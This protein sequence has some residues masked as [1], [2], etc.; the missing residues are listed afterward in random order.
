M[1]SLVRKR[2]H[3]AWGQTALLA[4]GLTGTLGLLLGADASQTP[5]PAATDS[6]AAAKAKNPYA[7]DHFHT[8]EPGEYVN[9][10]Q[11]QRLIGLGLE[12]YTTHCAGCHGDQGDGDGPAAARL[13]VKPRNF[14]AGV[15]KFRST[16]Q[17]QLPLEADLHRTITKGLPGASMPAF[18][19]M[20]ENDRVAV[21]EYL[22]TFVPDWDKLARQREVVPVPLAP[23]DFGSE[24]RIGRGRVV[25]LTMQCGRCHGMEG[26]GTNATIGYVDDPALGHIRPRNFTRGRYRGGNN[27]E[28][29]YRTFNTGLGGAMPKFD[30]SVI[31]YANQ[32]TLATQTAYMFPGEMKKL[33]PYAKQFAAD[34][35]A[36]FKLTE[37]EKQQLV[38]RNNW[39]LVSY[40]LSLTKDPKPTAPPPAPEVAPAAEA[41]T[42]KAEGNQTDSTSGDADGY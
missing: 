13:L 19:L 32:Q 29:V 14:K 23:M 36:L 15:F 9:Y 34:P 22:K 35:G 28:D 16:K 42:G 21:I 38:E 1:T 24:E 27:P 3:R 4:V 30:A 5:P 10:N 33:E 17:L 12:I 41:G 18:P 6:T 40:V 25:Y 8:N 39:D 11:R 2:K 37:T 26:A 31:L 20:P 7:L